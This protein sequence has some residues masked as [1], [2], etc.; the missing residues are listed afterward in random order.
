MVGARRTHSAGSLPGPEGPPPLTDEFS[1]R[2][3]VRSRAGATSCHH[4]VAVLR[5]TLSR[6]QSARLPPGRAGVIYRWRRVRNAVSANVPPVKSPS[7]TTRRVGQKAGLAS[8]AR[9]R[10]VGGRLTGAGGVAPTPPVGGG[11]IAEVGTASL[12]RF[13]KAQRY[14]APT[15]ATNVSD[16]PTSSPTLAPTEPS[17]SSS[18]HR[19]SR[20]SGR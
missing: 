15:S 18:T 13:V 3:R 16:W 12:G 8:L 2:S 6:P 9:D 11:L 5:R 19:A 1:L 20:A 7:A 14:S 10:S 4:A 17:G